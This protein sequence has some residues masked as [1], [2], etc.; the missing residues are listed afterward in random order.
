MKPIPVVQR[1]EDELRVT[2]VTSNTAMLWYILSRIGLKYSI[3][4][5]GQLLSEWPD[6][7]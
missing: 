5:Y 6:I 2:V 7:V 4:G 3:K 1:L